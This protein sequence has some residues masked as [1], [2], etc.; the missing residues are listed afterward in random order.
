MAKNKV[1]RNDGCPCGSGLKFKHCCE[2]QVDWQT[3]IEKPGSDIVRHL[4]IRGKNMLFMRY[5]ED[6]LGIDLDHPPTDWLQIKRS[7]TPGAVRQIHEAVAHVWPDHG[8]IARVLGAERM[9]HSALFIGNYDPSHLLRGV[10][11]HS[12]YSDSILLID[13]FTDHRITR[14]EYSPIEKPDQYTSQTLRNLRLWYMLRPWIEQ[15]IVRVIREPGDFD[16]PLKLAC[17]AKAERRAS[18]NPELEAVIDEQVE[19]LMEGDVWGLKEFIL[20]QH[21]D[22]ELARLYRQMR[23]GA[24]DEETRQAV[25]ELVER[26]DAHPYYVTGKA[27][28]SGRV[29]QFMMESAGTN[30][31]MARITAGMCGGHL[32]TDMRSRWKEIEIDRSVS[33]VADDRW[34][35]FAKAFSSLEMA[36]LGDVPL[37]AILDLRQGERTALLRAFLE[38]VWRS[39]ESDDPFRDRNAADLA[40]EL[41]QL[42]GQASGEWATAK[43]KLI[44]T[45]GK[46]AVLSLASMPIVG[47]GTPAWVAPATFA[48][49]AA[50]EMADF[51]G[52]QKGLAKRH[53]AALLL[54]LK[55]G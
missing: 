45:I 31:D 44:S 34:E 4:S 26:R 54:E 50:W 33:G 32:I 42:V 24:S 47:L 40:A 10:S 48:V 30:Y 27:D 29:W 6:A 9:H 38:Q 20:L 14:P 37:R 35:P 15:G 16:V 17:M 55:S 52:E 12:I 51:W 2:G 18:E 41:T 23:P 46:T 5:V 49:G 43:R 39:V 53:P 8:D 25:A 21:S 13:P 19:A 7:C 11:R 1:R 3:L 22:R 28:A 36:L